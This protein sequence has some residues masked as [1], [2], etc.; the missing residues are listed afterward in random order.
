MIAWER[1]APADGMWPN[2]VGM[3]E[4]KVVAYIKVGCINILLEVYDFE[5]GERIFCDWFQN[6][7][8]IEDIKLKAEIFVKRRKKQ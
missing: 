5:S 2:H 7:I 4:D 3:K 8:E 6:N 1:Y